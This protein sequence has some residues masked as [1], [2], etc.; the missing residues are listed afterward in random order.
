NASQANDG[1]KHEDSSSEE[2][3][4][5]KSGNDASSA[6]KID[7]SANAPNDLNV[8][9]KI[10]LPYGV[11]PDESIQIIINAK[12]QG[13]SFSGDWTRK[14]FAFPRF[15]I[16][17]AVTD[18]GVITISTIA[19]WAIIPENVMRLVPIDDA[20]NTT[21]SNAFYQNPTRFNK[22]AFRFLGQPYKLDFAVEKIDSRITA[23]VYSFHKLQPTLLNSHY[24]MNFNISEAELP[25]LTFLLPETSSETPNIRLRNSAVTNSNSGN[26]AA[27]I[28]EYTSEQVDIN[29]KKF[30]R[31][32]VDFLTP[33]QGELWLTVDTEQKIPEITSE[34]NSEIKL[35]QIIAE[36][37]V[38]QSDITAVEGHEELN[39]QLDSNESGYRTADVGELVMTEYKPG[40]MLV[41]IISGSNQD[42][43]IQVVCTR[44]SGYALTPT[45]VQSSDA[46]VHLGNDSKSLSEVTY[47]LKTKGT[48]LKI[49]LS[50]NDD[51]WSV[52]L[53]G[54]VIKPQLTDSAL[55]VDIP[56][57]EDARV[58]DLKMVYSSTCASPENAGELLRHSSLSIPHLYI[59]ENTSAN[60][61]GGV[62]EQEKT[63]WKEIPIIQT[64]WSVVPPDGYSITKLN[65]QL[66]AAVDEASS[67]KNNFVRVPKPAILNIGGGVIVAS[68]GLLSKTNP[69]SYGYRKSADAAKYSTTEKKMYEILPESSSTLSSIIIMDEE[70]IY[71]MDSVARDSGRVS[72]AKTKDDSSSKKSGVANKTQS[73]PEKDKAG[74]PGIVSQQ[75]LPVPPQAPDSAPYF[76]LMSKEKEQVRGK[77]LNSVQPVSIVVKSE[78]GSSNM[79]GVKQIGLGNTDATKLRVELVGKKF[80]STSVII[81]WVLTILVG[82]IFIPL[83]TGKKACLV[84][85]TA[86]LGTILVLIP[87]LEVY[88]N[89]VNAVVYAM[90]V[91][92]VPMFLIVGSAKLFSKKAISLMEYC[93]CNI[94]AKLVPVGA[95][96]EASTA[97][98]ASANTIEQPY[99]NGNTNSAGTAV[100]V[101]FL[102]VSA[103]AATAT[104]SNT[105]IADEIVV[106]TTVAS[107]NNKNV[108]EEMSKNANAVTVDKQLALL[109]NGATVDDGKIV[110]P[111]DAVIIPYDTN[112]INNS[113]IS[114]IESGDLRNPDQK[115][116]LPRELYQRFQDTINQK[117]EAKVTQP[118]VP[119]AVS[120]AKYETLLVTAKSGNQTNSQSETETDAQ[121]SQGLTSSDFITV[122]GVVNF[123]LFTDA[124]VLIPLQIAGAAVEIATLDGETAKLSFGTEQSD[125]AQTPLLKVE[126][127]GKH[128]LT[129]V[130]R[131]HVQRQGGWRMVAGTVPDF[132]CSTISLTVEDP[133]TE[134]ISLNMYDRRKF[135]SKTQDETIEATFGP[136]GFFNWRWR[137][138]VEEGVVDQSLTVVSDAQ[139]VVQEDGFRLNWD[140][141]L[142]L[143]NTGDSKM[144][145]ESFRIALPQGYTVCSVEGQNVR[146][147]APDESE[148]NSGAS[149]DSNLSQLIDIE[150]LKPA[151]ETEKI[152]IVLLKSEKYNSLFTETTRTSGDLATY[153]SD[154]NNEKPFEASVPR[155]E[156]LGAAMQT[157]KIMLLASQKFQIKVLDT[158]G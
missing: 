142:S 149:P 36:N 76:S 55:L 158:S 17:N 148:V 113:D 47:K 24:E 92:V 143:R 27:R 6:E 117:I 103:F 20:K 21:A 147:W 45:I 121:T 68:N 94:S 46:T 83:S 44:N 100:S 77:R 156:V 81:A 10:K 13:D 134:V 66:I 4:E 9:Y 102:I 85:C 124:P 26:I 72:S 110:L 57:S 114:V 22:V 116:I 101:M 131:Y 105:C 84:F 25:T 62:T 23:K 96:A 150:L 58:R 7:K 109:I 137:S 107:P 87:G 157:G 73:L 104:I 91:V 128:E 132:P 115:I 123:E 48:F 141:V 93:M 152:R 59:R 54:T 153:P 14:S 61:R 126:G 39:L 98:S 15:C 37:V 3:A 155:I 50:E 78:L 65:G 106:P 75:G 12:K 135:V 31:W 52:T 2:V 90:F 60:N 127:K 32:K 56:A 79:I 30:K 89:T 95:T 86:I 88:S 33:I 49:E 118:A 67:G 51:L 28:K 35:P 53:D 133:N 29:G 82:L 146:G 40:A 41:G 154:A 108:S 97:I 70:E 111:N 74:R 119:Y 43:P 129:L 64:K 63:G 140:M 144:R 136:L 125:N 34:K 19:D 138:K 1:V 69:F 8:T 99:K 151:D 11:N 145:P 42:S 16:N 18:S 120:S 71:E 139:F 38:W 130:L 122:K 5:S 112:L 80:A